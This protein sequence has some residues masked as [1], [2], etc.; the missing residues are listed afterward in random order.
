M[1]GIWKKKK[2]EWNKKI[3]ETFREECTKDPVVCRYEARLQ[4]LLGLY[5]PIDYP[6]DFFEK[7]PKEQSYYIERIMGDCKYLYRPLE[8]V[9]EDFFAKPFEEQKAA[10]LEIIDNY[11]DLSNVAKNVSKQLKLPKKYVKKRVE[12][13]YLCRWC[14]DFRHYPID[15]ITAYWSRWNGYTDDENSKIRILNGYSE[16]KLNNDLDYSHDTGKPSLLDNK[17]RVALANLMCNFIGK[18]IID[19][20]Y[21]LHTGGTYVFSSCPDAFRYY[22]LRHIKEVGFD[23]PIIVPE[24]FKEKAY[25][26]KNRKTPAGKEEPFEETRVFLESK[27]IR[28]W[29][30]KEKKITDKKGMTF[31][32][33]TLTKR[34]LKEIFEKYPWPEMEKEVHGC[35][36]EAYARQ[37]E[38]NRKLAKEK[39]AGTI[40]GI[41]VDVDGSL[42]LERYG[43]SLNKRLY[44]A[45]IEWQNAGEKVTIFTG[46][47]PL[48][49]KEKLQKVGVDL[50]RFPIESKSNYQNFI[51]TGYIIDDNSPFPQGF[52]MEN[53]ENYLLPWNP[54]IY[55]GGNMFNEILA[56]CKQ[57]KNLTEAQRRDLYYK[58]VIVRRFFAGPE[59]RYG[60]PDVK[61][62]LKERRKFADEVYSSL[63]QVQKVKE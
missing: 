50:N 20:N 39:A 27:T 29:I 24:V 37:V 45:M 26:E 30:I 31:I 49:A 19:G 56:K 15:L 11:P 14:H 42:Y 16:G 35:D 63:K 44:E 43:T 53:N 38:G 25:I 8:N 52:I 55:V 48:M 59:M 51:F 32:I 17:E 3:R 21:L 7:T 13:L 61:V 10:I 12:R 18:K 4:I 36:E 60:Y 62:R 57:N 34:D 9:L 54:D 58:L 1:F 28:E 46:G 40:D 23:A 5:P 47:D 22:T 33:P 2:D 6:E 41:F